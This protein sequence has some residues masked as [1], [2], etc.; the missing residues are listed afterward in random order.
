MKVLVAFADVR[1][2]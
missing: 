2:G 1:S